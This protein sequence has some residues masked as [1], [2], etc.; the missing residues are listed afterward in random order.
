MGQEGRSPHARWMSTLAW[1]GADLNHTAFGTAWGRL[2]GFVFQAGLECLVQFLKRYSLISYPVK[3]N[4]VM[5]PIN[6]HR[7]PP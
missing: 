6:L 4:P 3:L 7:A 5:F 1:L 2:V